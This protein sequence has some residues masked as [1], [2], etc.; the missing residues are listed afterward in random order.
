[1][2]VTD[3]LVQA[4]ERCAMPSRPPR[5]VYNSVVCPVRLARD[6]FIPP[7]LYRQRTPFVS[8]A[9]CTSNFLWCADSF[10]IDI[11]RFSPIPLLQSPAMKRSVKIFSID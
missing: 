5:E 2:Q 7:R 8:P 11:P 3:R 9:F 1:M 4:L 10:Q 6:L